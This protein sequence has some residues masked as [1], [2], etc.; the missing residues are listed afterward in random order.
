MAKRKI[1]QKP[2]EPYVPKPDT[3]I[4]IYIQKHKNRLTPI[5]YKFKLNYKYI[6]DIIKNEKQ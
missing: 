2:I 3:K 6:I 4:Y 1:E 5:P